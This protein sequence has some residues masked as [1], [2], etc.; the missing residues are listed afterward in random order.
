MIADPRATVSG[1][2]KAGRVRIPLGGGKGTVQAHQDTP[3]VSDAPE[4]DDGPVSSAPPATRTGDE[5]GDRAATLAYEDMGT[6]PN[7][8]LRTLRHVIAMPRGAC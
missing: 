1:V 4:A 6:I 7:D 8:A 3:N 5:C 2:Q